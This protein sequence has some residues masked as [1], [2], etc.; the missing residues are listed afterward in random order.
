MKEV[1]KI[2][3]VQV[4]N[5]FLKKQFGI[6][7]KGSIETNKLLKLKDEEFEFIEE[8]DVKGTITLTFE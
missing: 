3:I 4:D 2:E 5:S 1:K 6:I 7:D 8:N